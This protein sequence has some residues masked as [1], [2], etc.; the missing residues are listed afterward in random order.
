MENLTISEQEA[1]GRPRLGNLGVVD[2]EDELSTFAEGKQKLTESPALNLLPLQ[3][4]SPASSHLPTSHQSAFSLPPAPDADALFSES[5]EGGETATP[6]E[7]APAS[8]RHAGR[9]EA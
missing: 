8:G 1:N 5:R 6:V 4:E 3:V 7:V 9:T 2:E